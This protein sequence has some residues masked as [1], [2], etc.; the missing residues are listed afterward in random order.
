L[1]RTPVVA[2]TANALDGEREKCLEAGMDDY[3]AKPFLLEEMA[4]TLA[5]WLPQAAPQAPPEPVWDARA[6]LEKM[7]GDRELL[8]EMKPLFVS[9]A[10]KH[11]ACLAPS[12]EPQTASAIASAAHALKGM[13]M[14]F[15]AKE[16]TDLAA[17]VERLARDGGIGQADP[18]VAQL[19][20]AV[21]R[22]VTAL[23]EDSGD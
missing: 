9:E 15:C 5:R 13:A 10:P 6:A 2:L 11:L 3:L 12:A 17:Q 14:H 20:R 21:E 4:Q 1:P 18:L 8:A 16:V 7:G 22:L 19:V 23:R